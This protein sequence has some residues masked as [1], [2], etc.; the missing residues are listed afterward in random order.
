[1]SSEG[2]SRSPR[3]LL[4]PG[5]DLENGK[6]DEDKEEEEAQQAA[7]GNGAANGRQD[8]ESRA[9]H[10]GSFEEDAPPPYDA[11]PPLS[12]APSERG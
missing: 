7:V 2:P 10:G 11:A 5:R 12:R 4:P 6:V 3:H 1:M 9:T 8:A